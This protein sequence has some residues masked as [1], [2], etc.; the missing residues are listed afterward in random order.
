MFDGKAFG[1]EIVAAVK[2]HV[3]R[4]MSPV[5][6]RL[7]AM[8]RRLAE[9]AVGKADLDE[10]RRGIAA[11]KEA[12]DALPAPKELPDVGKM[13]ADAIAAIPA[14]LVEKEP[15]PALAELAARLEADT[16]G[17]RRA[18]AEAEARREAP[19]VAAA[20]IADLVKGEAERILAGWERPQDGKSVTVADVTPLIAE[21]VAKA[22]AAIPAPKDGI[23]LAGAVIDRKGHL[24]VTTTDGRPHDLGPVVG[25]DADMAALRKE[26]AEAVAA[27]PKPKDGLDG[28]GFDDMTFEVRE[29]GAY[30]VWEKGDVVKEARLPIPI[31][32]GVFKE[33][34][35]YRAGDGVTWGGHY[36]FAQEETAEKPDSGKGWRMAVRKGRDGKDAVVKQAPAPGPVKVG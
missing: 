33:G 11:L 19:D 7:E 3:E 30:L 22:V 16:A 25:A 26:L 5:L 2:Q 14:P 18:L 17:F 4:A 21:Q 28:V 12:V 8:E 35:T 27:L 23:G 20:R 34:Q 10:V 6:A 36:W 15:D 32:R 1:Q 31:D 29:T 24:V 13:I 9:P